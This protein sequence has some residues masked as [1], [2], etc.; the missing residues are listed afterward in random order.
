MPDVTVV[1]SA[2][3]D[4]VASVPR[5][6]LPGET[7]LA[8]G[9]AEHPGGKG[10]N[11]AV[12]AARSGAATR[13]VA[14]VGDDPA[15]VRL[16]EIVHQE[17]IQPD[18]AVVTAPSGRALI[19]V[20]DDGENSIVVVPG[21]N[22]RLVWPGGDP[23]TVVLAQLEVPIDTV[24]AAFDDARRSG[25][26]T[27][28]NPAPARS[29]PASLLERCDVVVPNEHELELVGGVD[30]LRA[31]GVRTIVVTRGAAGVEVVHDGESWHEPP[32]QIEPVDTTGA[33][34]A[35]C[36]ALAARLALGDDL[37]AA[38]RWAVAAGGLATTVVGAVPSMP[39]ADAIAAAVS[40]AARARPTP[41]G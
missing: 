4:L 7:L 41:P 14:A 1:G 5:C 19:S 24:V 31:A 10:L 37:R 2:N 12:A 16:R 40:A 35:F 33:G 9:Y 28:L 32:I 15:G 25:A 22:A 29:L 27:I 11:Q 39:A 3:L 13:L 20:G 34:D 36:G 21:A 17:G 26:V 38:V 30:G 6:P 23:G 8:H 18:V